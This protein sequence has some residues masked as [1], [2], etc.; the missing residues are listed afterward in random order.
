VTLGAG[1]LINVET[2]SLLT[3]SDARFGGGSASGFSYVVISTDAAVAA[4]TQLIVNASTLE[5]GENLTFDGHLE[6]DGSF[7]IY[8]G[9]GND[10]LTGGAKVDVFFFGENGRFGSGDH[11]DGGAGAD[12]LVLRGDYH[13]VMDGASMTNIETVTLMSGADARFAPAGT[14]FHY[15][16]STADNTVA[17][18]ATMTFNGGD[19]AAGETLHFDGSAETNGAFRVFGG[20][21]DDVLVGGA[22]G[23]LLFGGLGADQLTGGGGNDMF[24]YQS[25]SESTASALDHILDFASGDRIDMSR[26]GHF[27]FIGGNG[28]GG[29]AGELR[30]ENVSGNVWSVQ[31]DTNG[32]GSADFVLSVTVADNHAL[33]ASDFA[34]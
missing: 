2:L 34:F 18:G 5:A 16:I 12:I 33:T 14:P 19:L 9:Q 26:A 23:D 30:V 22:G 11:V 20:K 15:D 25:A 17:A 31:A 7:F 29:H 6:T 28:F 21:A 10:T 32:D 4:G 1:S 3:H 13:I 24:R 27:D 8:G